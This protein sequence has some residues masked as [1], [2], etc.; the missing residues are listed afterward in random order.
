MVIY[1]K[2]GF[3]WKIPDETTH[4]NLIFLIE[5]LGFELL[6]DENI[7]ISDCKVICSVRNPY[8][9]VLSLFINLEIIHR[10]ALTKEIKNTIIKYFKEWI[11]ICFEKRKLVVDLN[12]YGKNSKIV[13]SL[14]ESFFE[15][16]IPDLYIK[17]ENIQDDLKNIKSLLNIGSLEYHEFRDIVYPIDMK[18][19]YKDFYDVETAKLVY[20]YF[21]NHF[22]LFDYDPF[23][24]TN[25]VL[26]DEIKIKFIH[27]TF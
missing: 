16:K 26:S 5:K 15:G 2:E 18:Y 17:N 22:H 11:H 21:F 9:R 6:V 13:Q 4:E 1:K 12:D 24:F 8:E 7:D 25:E 3:V 10:V 23:S 19:D 27:D 20:V 14:Q